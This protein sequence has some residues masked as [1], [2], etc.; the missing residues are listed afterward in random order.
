[1]PD[2]P[3]SA[4]FEV[5]YYVAQFVSLRRN[6]ICRCLYVDLGLIVN[7]CWPV[8]NLEEASRG[9]SRDKNELLR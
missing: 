2:L 7:L 9:F 3:C 8:T 6:G 5:A 1:M 4:V